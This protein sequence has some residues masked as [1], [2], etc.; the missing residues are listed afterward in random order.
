ML[1]GTQYHV[2]VYVLACVSVVSVLFA[3][4]E[5]FRCSQCHGHSTAV[6]ANS[7]IFT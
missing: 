6:V 4:Y 2:C 1:L 3:A 5:M 7:I